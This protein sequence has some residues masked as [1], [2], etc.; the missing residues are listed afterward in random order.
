MSLLDHPFIRK[1]GP[2]LIK[3]AVAGGLGATIDLGSLTLFVEQFGMDERV[4]VV[5]STLCAVI[6]VFLLNKHFTFKNKDKQVGKQ[7]AKFAIVYGVAILSNI[8]IS[9]LLITAGLH[10]LL[11]KIAAIGG[12]AIWNYAMSHGFVF[13][14]SEA[15]A[16]EVVIV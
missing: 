10:Y 12:G 9:A 14:Q 7:A 5:P 6:V 15:G 13:K 2:Q 8:I 11:A 3:F 16:E 1:H 4:A